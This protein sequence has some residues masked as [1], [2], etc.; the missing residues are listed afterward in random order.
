M[1]LEP[2]RLSKRFGYRFSNPALLET[3]LTHR[4]A[5]SVNNERMEFLGDAILGYLI[6]AEL[7]HRFPTA[8]EGELSRLRAS[9][10]K[11]ETL[12]NIAGQLELGEYLILGPGEMKSGGFRR[13]SILADAFEAVIGAVYLD[14][15]IST[16]RDVILPLFTSRLEECDPDRVNKDPKTRLQEYLQARGAALP[17]YEVLAITGKSHNQT[18]EVACQIDGLAEQPVGTGSSRRIAEQAAAE[19]A[20]ELLGA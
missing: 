16:V 9:L 7:F 20:L 6:S 3:A 13:R 4:S 12:A 19:Q 8:T 1:T 17:E 5:G 2:A 11:G 14:S 15:D 18:F 10:V